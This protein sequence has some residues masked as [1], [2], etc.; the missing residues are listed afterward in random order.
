MPF[1]PKDNHI[2]VNYH[3]VRE[4]SAELSGIH[5]CPPREFERQLQFLSSAY[6][7]AGIAEVFAAAQAGSEEKLCAL[8]FDDGFQDNLENAVPVLERYGATAT[9][10]PIAQVF[11]GVLPATHK[12]H[13]VLSK[14]LVPELV[15]RFN[16]FLGERAPRLSGTYRIP[17]DRRITTAR[18]IFDDIPTANFKETMSIVPEEIKKK[19][20]NA[21][22]REANLEERSLARG[23]FMSAAELRQLAAMGH[24]IGSHGFTHDALDC[25]NDA[26]V[27]HEIAASKEI[28][29]GIAGRAI[30][31]FSY[32]QSA[33]SADIFAALANVGFTHAVT[34]NTIRGVAPDDH[35]FLIP[36]YDT[37]DV[38]DFLNSGKFST[39]SN[40]K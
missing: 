32:P 34:V 3:Y 8:T 31:L 6:R 20:L 16:E 2:V 17:T 22:L 29:G 1:S 19:F 5:P 40:N 12:V 35:P 37:N 18:K 13:I 25:L 21:L 24:A 7:I 11:E 36:R 30:T 23:L 10:F 26:E 28:I 27:Q 33:P 38:R 4:P 9:F 39:S 14:F 15:R